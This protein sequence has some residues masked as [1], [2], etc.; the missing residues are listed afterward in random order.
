MRMA[1]ARDRAGKS[2][3]LMDEL[4]ILDQ[5][6]QTIV[7]DHVGFIQRLIV[8]DL[9]DHRLILDEASQCRLLDPLPI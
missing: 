6:Y 1:L 3:R 4:D 5:G 7:L 9:V 2:A 8:A